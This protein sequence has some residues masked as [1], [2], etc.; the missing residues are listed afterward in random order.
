M[1]PRDSSG[2]KI[3]REA[4]CQMCLGLQN[5]V[6]HTE[7]HTFIARYRIESGSSIPLQTLDSADSSAEVNN[8]DTR[9]RGVGV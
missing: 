9:Y 1:P 7:K 3:F 6:F 4:P 5:H 8:M 2:C